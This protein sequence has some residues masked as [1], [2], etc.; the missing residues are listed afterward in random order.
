MHTFFHYPTIMFYIMCFYMDD[1]QHK[2]RVDEKIFYKANAISIHKSWVALQ[3]Y[4]AGLARSTSNVTAV[5]L[6]FL[7][8]LL[9]MFMKTATANH[10]YRLMEQC[11]V[12]TLSFQ[13]HYMTC[14]ATGICLIPNYP[15]HV[16]IF[17]HTPDVIFCNVKCIKW[18]ASTVV[19]RVHNSKICCQLTAHNSLF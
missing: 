15:Q 3:L 17:D 8:I 13:C 4:W 7:V 1:I 19:H 2:F 18:S 16:G 9:K 5:W 6:A 11:E 14:R 12:L 10:Q